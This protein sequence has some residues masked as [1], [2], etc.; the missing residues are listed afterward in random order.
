MVGYNFVDAI[1]RHNAYTNN[2]K[3]I[4]WFGVIWSLITVGVIACF[5]WLINNY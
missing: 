1:I 5:I 2:P 4:T 3:T